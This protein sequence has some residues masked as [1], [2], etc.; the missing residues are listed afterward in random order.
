MMSRRF[1][2]AAFAATLA[3][4]TVALPAQADA[5]ADARAFIQRLAD[6]AM[7][8]VAVKGLSDDERARRFRTLFVDTF[9]LPEIGKLVLGRYWRV[10]TPEQQ[11]EF[12]RL[13]EEI[14]VYT[15]TKRFRDYSGE[16]LDILALAPEGENDVL[17]DS[18]IKRERLEPINV[19]W[20]V[21][22]SADGFKVLDIKVEGA[23][24]AFTHRSEYASVIQGAGGQVE[25]L[26][27]AMRKK[28]AQMQV[29]G[30]TA[31]APSASKAN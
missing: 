15:W 25:G 13:F 12:L 16:T 5:N 29:E 6:T 7:N 1:L 22:K 24:M 31:A 30:A 3:L 21:R 18:R 4:F 17:V 20:R 2:I 8:T 14:Q 11:Q 10:A 23:S 28:V 19:A 9:D 27:A 26:L